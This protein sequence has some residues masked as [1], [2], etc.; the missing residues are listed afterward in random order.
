MRGLHAQLLIHFTDILNEPF[1]LCLHEE[2]KVSQIE[3][4]NDKPKDVN[5]AKYQEHAKNIPRLRVKQYIFHSFLSPKKYCLISL[6]Y[7][8]T[9]LKKLY[10]RDSEVSA[11][12][13]SF[14]FIRTLYD[15]EHDHDYKVK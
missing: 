9:I 8:L 13:V 14:S 5:I 15:K 7:I 10:K 12:E 3:N 6:Q 1:D 4:S 11:H 2:F